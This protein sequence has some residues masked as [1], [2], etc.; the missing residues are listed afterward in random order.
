MK[1]Q[2]PFGKTSTIKQVGYYDEDETLVVEFNDGG[3]YEYYDVPKHIYNDLLLGNN[4][5]KTLLKE[6]KGRYEYEKIK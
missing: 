5:G 6:V 1:W 4:P 2:K 3:I